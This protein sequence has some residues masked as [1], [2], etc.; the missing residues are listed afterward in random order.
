MNFGFD[1]LSTLG[2]K[3]AFKTEMAWVGAMTEMAWVIED[4]V[5]RKE[6]KSSNFKHRI[7]R[8]GRHD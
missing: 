2:E 6:N 4:T 3:T 8:D 1:F 7:K 5:N